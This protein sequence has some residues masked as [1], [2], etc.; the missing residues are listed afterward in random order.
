[1]F[2][3]RWISWFPLSWVWRVPLLLSSRGLYHPSSNG[4]CI[5]KVISKKLSGL[6]ISWLCVE[7]IFLMHSLG[8]VR[9]VPPK[10]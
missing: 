8:L 10:L 9:I 6:N 7:L 4:A 2:C 1:M 5:E 3:V